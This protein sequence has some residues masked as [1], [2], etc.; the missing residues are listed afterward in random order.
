MNDE[1]VFA[2]IDEKGFETKIWLSEQK[3]P[4][5]QKISKTNFKY[6]INLSSF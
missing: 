1:S 6:K 3:F 2:Y 5:K 4:T